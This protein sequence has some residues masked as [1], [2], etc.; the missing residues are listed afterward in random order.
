ML[1][2]LFRPGFKTVVLNS[3]PQIG[4]Q[5]GTPS[6]NSHARPIKYRFDDVVIKELRSRLSACSLYAETSVMEQ[7]V[8]LLVCFEVVV[9]L[10]KTVFRIRPPKLVNT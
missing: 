3:T 5:I 7:L 2:L 4:T 8:E 10:G 6:R 1:T 9:S